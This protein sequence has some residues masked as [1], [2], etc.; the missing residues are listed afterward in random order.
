MAPRT[1]AYLAGMDRTEAFLALTNTDPISRRLMLS[2]SAAQS[3]LTV[4]AQEGV[5][6]CPSFAILHWAG[7]FAIVRRSK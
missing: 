5:W 3:A 2:A 6:W 7:E 4:A 1:E